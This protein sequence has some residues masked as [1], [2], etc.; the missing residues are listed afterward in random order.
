[1]VPKLTGFG[2]APAH[3][4][5]REGVVVAWIYGRGGPTDVPWIGVAVSVQATRPGRCCGNTLW[6]KGLSAPSKLEQRLLKSSP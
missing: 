5:Y 6:A 1:M 4:W 2:V 3:Q